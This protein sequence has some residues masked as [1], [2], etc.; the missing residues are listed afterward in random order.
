MIDKVVAGNS[1]RNIFFLLV[2]I[3]T[4]FTSCEEDPSSIGLDLIPPKDKVEVSFT[5]SFSLLSSTNTYDSLITSH[6]PTMLLGSYLV[7]VFGFTKASFYSEF[8]YSQ[9]NKQFEENAKFDSLVFYFIVDTV[10]GDSTAMQE[11]NIYEM[12][13]TLDIGQNYFSSTELGIYNDS[14]VLGTKIT[15]LQDT[16]LSIPL[17]SD[18]GNYLLEADTTKFQSR[19]NFLGYFNGLYVTTNLINKNGSLVKVNLASADTR[20]V[21]YYHTEEDTLTYT[22][23]PTTRSLNKLNHDYQ[24]A[25]FY[26]ELNDSPVKSENL[27]VQG[28]GGVRSEI[29]IEGLD[30]YKGKFAVSKAELIVPLDTVKQ[31]DLPPLN[32]LILSRRNEEGVLIPLEDQLLQDNFIGGIYDRDSKAYTFSIPLHIQ[33]YFNDEIANTDI[34]ISANNS[35]S[36]IG[37]SI[38]KGEGAANGIRL[39]LF[40]NKL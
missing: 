6:K 3:I 10:V 27:F 23:F 22:Y 28:T 35:S 5:D 16:L 11:I 34:I 4:I 8:V 24:Q 31:G 40:L 29:K 38:L 21:L 14:K 37:H 20:L 39:R 17:S 30:E 15:N 12:T 19:E 18:L 7:D 32:M 2:V 1:F 9:A 36:T 25:D 33:S 13:D 26:M